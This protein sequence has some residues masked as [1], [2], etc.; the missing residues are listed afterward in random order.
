MKVIATLA[1]MPPRTGNWSYPP[2][3]DGY[4]TA[5]HAAGIMGYFDQSTWTQIHKRHP[6]RGL[7]KDGWNLYVPYEMLVCKW[8]PSWR[9]RKIFAFWKKA[10]KSSGC[11]EWTGPRNSTSGYGQVNLFGKHQTAHRWSWEL[12]NGDIPKGMWILHRCD[13]PPCFNPEHLFLGTPADNVLDAQ[14][15]GRRPSIVD[16][17][18]R[19]SCPHGDRPKRVRGACSPCYT[20]WRLELVYGRP[21][22]R[23]LRRGDG[24]CP[25]CNRWTIH[26]SRG[27]CI[28]CYQ[29]ARYRASK[30]LADAA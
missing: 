18:V 29:K 22:T 9:A 1:A 20:R 12:T 17:A 10:D 5:R 8:R 30:Q 23:R 15:K 3:R 25:Q 19:V 7:I 6:E 28:S 2:E 21:L 11:W 24:A 16:P 26:W 27:L 13:N 14:I 4:L